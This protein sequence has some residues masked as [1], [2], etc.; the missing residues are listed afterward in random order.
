MDGAQFTKGFTFPA[1]KRLMDWLSSISDAIKTRALRS[2]T[3]TGIMR[4]VFGGSDAS[5]AWNWRMAY[6]MMQAAARLISRPIREYGA[7]QGGEPTGTIHMSATST[8]DRE[9]G[10]SRLSEG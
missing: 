10:E 8:D 1:H 7:G 9:K 6:D 5:G 3:L 4:E 2:S